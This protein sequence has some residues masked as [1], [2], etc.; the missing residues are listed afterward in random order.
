MVRRFSGRR[1]G[2]ASSSSRRSGRA[3]PAP[4]AKNAGRL[5][6]DVRG[7]D[8]DVVLAQRLGEAAR[9][10]RRRSNFHFHLRPLG[11]LEIMNTLQTN[12]S[13]INQTSGSSSTR[14]HHW[15]LSQ[16]EEPHLG[17]RKEG[18]VY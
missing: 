7:L 2:G 8:V 9:V 1:R 17:P 6:V 5:N 12:E 18:R 16:G 14:R 4:S 15:S 11:L 10:H 13:I 3:A